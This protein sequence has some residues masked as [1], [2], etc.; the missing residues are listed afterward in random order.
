MLA[1]VFQSIA[2]DVMVR[3]QEAQEQPGGA[4]NAGGNSPLRVQP[5]SS[6]KKAGKKSGGCC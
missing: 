4:A 2:R 1:Q 6:S 5:A 3:L